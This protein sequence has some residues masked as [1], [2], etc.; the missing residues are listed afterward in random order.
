M[1]TGSHFVL[2]ISIAGL[3]NIDPAITNDSL[4]AQA[5]FL[6]A[7]IGSQAPDFD[8]VTKFIG[9]NPSYIRHHRGI[10]H[11]FSAILIWPTLIT[12][13]L[14]LF[15][16]VNYFTL[17]TWIFI[18]V[19]F[20]IFLD[21]LNAYGTQALKPISEKW[22]ALNILNIFDPF[23][24]VVHTVAIILWGLQIFDPVVIFV[25][26]Y[27][28]TAA[29]ILWRAFSHI[30]VK[31]LLINDYGKKGI[32][33]ILPTINWSVYN[34]IE[35]LP[36][37]YEISILRKNKLTLIDSRNK[38]EEN[39]IIK[40]SKQDYKIKAFLYFSSFAYP[41][42]KK[43]DLGYR[44][45]WIDLR[46]RFNNHYPFIGVSILADD[47]TPVGS[48]VGWVYNENYFKKKIASLVK[49]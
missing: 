26:V 6:G 28:L 12:L 22:I 24:F 15:F 40:A 20:H 9:G 42:Y 49:N 36:D 10:T 35:E 45:I 18:S 14:L 11:S 38:I 17:W 25:S 31:N 30:K 5:V 7:I 27:L 4:L 23:I 3:S 39:Q 48:Y 13:I 2:G 8:A 1:D 29:Y 34:I 33:T 16:P 19:V 47:L 44:V 41:E 46:Y 43:I 37:K 21:L 32:I